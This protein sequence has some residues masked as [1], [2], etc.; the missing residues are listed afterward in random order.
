M[1]TSDEYY[2]GLDCGTNSVGWAVTD[3]NYKIMRAKGKNLW[4]SR[5]F[6]EANTAAERRQHRS[7]RRRASRAKQRIRLLQEIFSSEISKVDPDFYIRLRQSAFLEEDKEGIASNSKNTIFNDPEYTDKDYHQCYPTIWHLRKDIIDSAENSSKHFDIRLYYLAIAHIVK[8]RG[9]FLNEGGFEGNNIFSDIFNEFIEAAS[10]D[11]F[12]IEQSND[13]AIEKTLKQKKIPLRKLRQQLCE[14]LFTNNDETDSQDL[15]RES[16]LAG[17]IAGSTVTP[18]KIFTD[19]EDDAI[20]LSFS[21]DNFDEKRP[22]IEQSIGTSHMDLVIAAKKLYDFSVLSN[23]LEDNK[24]ISQAMVKKYDQHKEDLKD[25]KNV[26]RA[27]PNDYRKFFS[28][29]LL[30]DKKAVNYLAYVGKAYTQDTSGRKKS[31]S[32]SQEEINKEISK[33]LLKNG[34]TEKTPGAAGKLLAKA[35]MLELLPKQKGQA[36]GTIPQQLHHNELRIILS[37]LV[38]DFPSFGEANA[39]EDTSFN[40][41]SLKIERIHDFRIPYYCGPIVSNRKS[42]FSWGDEEINEL[43]YPWN[44]EKVVDIDRRANSFIRRMTNECTYLLGEDVLPKSS[45]LYQRYMV[46]NELNNLKINGRRISDVKIKQKIF[47]D[48][49]MGS[50]LKGN[51][52]LKN[53]REW[54]LQNS[55]I[56][57][58]DDLSGTSEVKI[59]PKLST[60]NDFARTLGTD[61]E[62]KYTKNQL[63]YT[64]EL[65]TIL[66]NEKAMLKRKIIETLGCEEEKASKLARLNYRDWGRFSQKFLTGIKVGINGSE[67][68]I[69]DELYETNNNLME[70]LGS[71]YGF[72][73]KIAEYNK[74]K[75]LAVG[76]ISYNDISSLYCSPSVKRTIWQAVRIVNE[77]VEVIGR[78]PKKIFL[79]STREND[80]KK[81]G[82]NGLSRKKTLE[83]FYDSIKGN[84]KDDN[85]RDLRKEL[86]GQQDR[87][88][89]NRKLYLYFTQM[90]RCAYCGREIDIED[91]NNTELYDIDHI[92]P[93]SKTKDDSISRNLVLV[94]ARENREKTNIYPISENIR[95]KMHQSWAYWLHVGLITKEKYER[96][97]RNNPLTDDELGSFIARQLVETS[98][99]VKAMKE[100]FSAGYPNSNIVMVKANIVSELR[101]WFG[102]DRKNKSGDIIHTGL[103]EFV[104]VRNIND[105]HHAK[106]AYL[107]IVVGNVIDTTFSSNP[108]RWVHEHK[109]NVTDDGR[110]CASKDYSL[111]P[112]VLWRDQPGSGPVIKGWGYSSSISTISDTL[113]RN[114]VLWTRMTTEQKGELFKLSPVGKS[115]KT[116]GILPLK[117]GMD[118]KKY[119]GYNSIAGAYFAL[120]ECMEKGK[121]HRKIVQIPQIEKNDEHGYIAKKYNNAKIII[122]KIQF[123]SLF[124]I[125]GNRMNLYGRAGEKRLIFHHALQAK[126]L[127]EFSAYLK[128]VS[129]VVEKDKKLNKKYEIDEHDNVTAEENIRIFDYLSSKAELL[130][131]FP[132]LGGKMCNI[133][134]AKDNFV[135]LETKAQCLAINEIAKLFTCKAESSD[136][137]NIIPGA[138]NIGLCRISND[139]TNLDSALLVNQSPTGLYETIIDLKSVKLIKTES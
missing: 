42:E 89:Q 68:S 70:L 126:I 78:P 101:S 136:L 12:N 88:L 13:I 44:F 32:C 45:F 66:N 61:F 99:S 62:K 77:L 122:P 76:K 80:Y 108:I 125:N 35:N 91:I 36:K 9:H 134:K 87:N 95:L 71:G 132:E 130:A 79:E 112:W 30:T 93:R 34:I 56:L 109:G 52:T 133:A 121:L 118:P 69:I 39:N 10:S 50:Q 100:L 31:V 73:E 40:T 26:F 43:V 54:L 20:K 41:K 18:Q 72:S 58:E 85:Y 123:K 83:K 11:G 64:V 67:V 24:S 119:G 19:S 46:L 92:Y 113:K 127:P 124:I 60:Y 28:A 129:K 94:H 49:F 97:S 128:K 38:K 90:G 131:S 14:L 15:K 110:D 96:L 22:E 57:P 4:G 104:K 51:P 106:D 84:S 16:E 103:P 135:K 33:I 63:E 6:D 115:E 102:N 98:Q 21:S 111:N 53:L 81:A 1:S 105:L 120:I 37:K 55:L 23:L 7:A 74:P 27:W 86:D 47:N 75:K 29:A 3:T 59:L 82:E 2:I 114:D 116:D 65:I 5:L 139:I 137:S 138:N 117:K 107:N 48:C 8:N 25:I 17:L